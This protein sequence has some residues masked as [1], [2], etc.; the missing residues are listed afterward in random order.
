MTTT[1]TVK[2]R[3]F[4]PAVIATG[5]LGSIV[6]ALSMNGT[7]AAFAAKIDN[8]NNF[9]SVKAISLEEQNEGGTDTSNNCTATT[10]GAAAQCDTINKFGA[11]QFTPGAGGSSTTSIQ[12]RNTGSVPISAFKL[13]ADVCKVGTVN[14]NNTPT[15]LTDDTFAA[16]STQPT[17][18]T[19]TLCGK[20]NVKVDTQ[21]VT[22]TTGT[23]APAAGAGWTN[24]HNGVA[25]SLPTTD[26]TAIALGAI[27]A[28]ST[29]W[30]QFTTSV[31]DADLSDLQGQAAG[32][33][34]HWEASA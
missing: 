11:A 21:V 12:M 2:R 29:M 7:L 34:L 1:T 27:P 10:S 8:T 23:A 28:G 19:A 6:M 26:A 16:A 15:D 30:V 24:V 3:R 14:D 5:A 9:A 31:A 25:T 32:Q 4:T 22:G 18:L 13:W 33:V 20:M 17:D